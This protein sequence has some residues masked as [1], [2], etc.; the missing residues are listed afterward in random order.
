[1]L[2]LVRAEFLC[3]VCDCRNPEIVHCEG[4][5]LVKIPNLIIG[6]YPSSVIVLR[7]PRLSCVD[8]KAFGRK[9]GISTVSDCDRIVTTT[10]STLGTEE[11]EEE[12]VRIVN[13]SKLDLDLNIVLELCILIISVIMCST[14]IITTCCLYLIRKELH[15]R[16][17]PRMRFRDGRVTE[18]D[19]DDDRPYPTQHRR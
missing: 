19:S 12:E 13:N 11:E 18:S 2:S 4:F 17:P 16:D 3:E 15:H 5:N 6:N 10:A 7:N 8:I 1:M 9:T 14:L